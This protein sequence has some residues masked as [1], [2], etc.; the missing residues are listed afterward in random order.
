MLCQADRS[1]DSCKPSQ[2]KPRPEVSVGSSNLV[3]VMLTGLMLVLD[4]E[5]QSFSLLSLF[6]L[7]IYNFRTL[8]RTISSVKFC[9]FQWHFDDAGLTSC[10]CHDADMLV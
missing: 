1:S 4:C 10:P 9:N 8:T 5:A 2:P 3:S 6:L 7:S